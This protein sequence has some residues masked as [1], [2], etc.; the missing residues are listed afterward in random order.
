MASVLY[1]TKGRAAFLTLNRPDRLNAIDMSMPTLIKSAVEKA[2]ADPHIRVIVLQGAGR[3]FCSGYDL[4]YFAEQPR[5]SVLGSQN[6]PWDPFLDY[7]YMKLCTDCYM[8]LFHS[9][10]PTICKVHGFA[11]A[12]G[13]DIALCCDLVI[14]AD[15]AK[16]GY[17][18][19]RLWGSPTTAMWVY[20]VGPE[21][22]K[23]LLFTGDLIDGNKAKQIGLVLES[24]P[25][26][27]L[28]SYVSILVQRISS[29]PSNQLF[30]H[31]QV[32][33]NAI[34]STI[35]STQRFATLADGIA[36]HTPEGVAFQNR[37]EKIG[38]NRAVKERDSGQDFLPPSSNS[39]EVLISKL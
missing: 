31:K 13:S 27:S 30:L 20:R 19:A 10:K 22:A 36:R 17:P 14:M 23:H 18:P 8:S 12:G 11:V 9:Y 35:S 37:V 6:M 7:Q 25:S 26:S 15:D 33:H 34:E 21:K 1:E 29:V 39:R 16:I 4:K 2:N 28:D 24:V 5:G 3:A 32:I 38:F